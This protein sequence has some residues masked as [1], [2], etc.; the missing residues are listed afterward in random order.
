MSSGSQ[1][2][3]PASTPDRQDCSATYDGVEVL[4]GE[5]DMP[6]QEIDLGTSLHRGMDRIDVANYV[7]LQSRAAFD[8]VRADARIWAG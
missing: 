3:L 4:G 1:A 7:Q 6:G 2:R 8:A 5:I